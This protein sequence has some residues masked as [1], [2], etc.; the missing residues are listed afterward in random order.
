MTGFE[1]NES[2]GV[3]PM[4]DFTEGTVRTIQDAVDRLRAEFLEMPGLRLKPVQVQRLC[5]LEP[6]MCLMAL[7]VLVSEKFLCELGG[8]YARLTS[9]HHPKPAKAALDRDARVRAS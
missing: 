3:S 8:Y 2:F 4:C 7:D 9:G 5:G 1:Q 6:I